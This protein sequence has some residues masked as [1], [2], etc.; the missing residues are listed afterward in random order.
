VLLVLLACPA[1]HAQVYRWVDSEGV[2]HLSSEK[3]PA[4]VKAERL[5]VGSSPR[6]AS[7]GSSSRSS[8]GSAGS[9]A[10]ASGAR[11]PAGST[12]S[13]SDREELLGR[14][15]NR[16]CVIA[17]EA[18]ER[19]TSGTEVSSADE[20]RRLKQTADLNCSQNPALRSRQEEM[21][22]Q[23]RASNSPACVEARSQLGE[24]TAPGSGVPREQ[25][26]AQQAFVEDHCT[27]PV[28]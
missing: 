17:L 26:R 28:R 14:L 4:G 16:E 22:L 12:V 15:R 21:A 23:L 25:L 1:A 19:K 11:S 6:S 18:L 3:P 9:V 8:G 2:V 10:S 13:A 24:M 27:S 5:N 7:T 20:I